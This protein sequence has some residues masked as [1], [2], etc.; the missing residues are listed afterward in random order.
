MI[1]CWDCILVVLQDESGWSV[2]AGEGDPVKQ[3]FQGY[4]RL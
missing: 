1:S 2:E 4:G 3:H